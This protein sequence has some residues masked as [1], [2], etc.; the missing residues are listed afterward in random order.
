MSTVKMIKADAQIA[1]TFGVS[2]IKKLQ[3][4]LLYLSEERSI[5]ELNQFKELA[6]KQEE[7]P[8]AWMDHLQTMIILV[9][10]IES[11]AEKTNQFTEVNPD[12]FTTQ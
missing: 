3:S 5:E 11:T 10:E 7:F 9:R 8:E 12:S 1:V 6:E 4:L 2:F